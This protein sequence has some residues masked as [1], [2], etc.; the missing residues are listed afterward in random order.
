M[1]DLVATAN[2]VY[3]RLGLARIVYIYTVYG[4][5]LVLSITLDLASTSR[6]THPS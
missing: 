1:D 6:P 3:V 2:G 4:R 5:I